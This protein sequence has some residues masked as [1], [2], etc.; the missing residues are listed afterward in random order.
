MSSGHPESTLSVVGVVLA[1]GALPAVG[2]DPLRSNDACDKLH[3]FL[4]GWLGGPALYVQRLGHPRLRARHLPYAIGIA[5]R[6]QWLACMTQAMG[7]CGID[8]ALTA[9]LDAAFFSTAD[10]MRN[11]EG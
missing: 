6:Y 9:R 5:E 8:A 2:A 11:R 7:E 1:A 10:W 4:C 3:W